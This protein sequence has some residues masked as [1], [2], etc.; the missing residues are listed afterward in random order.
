[1][2]KHFL[3][4]AFVLLLWSGCEEQVATQYLSAGYPYELFDREPG[5]TAQLG[6]I[7]YYR[8]RIETDGGAL[9]FDGY[10]SIAAGQATIPEDGQFAKAKT[11]YVLEA[12]TKMS[13]GDSLVLRLPAEV[14]RQESA[15][16]PP[17]K[18][19]KE[20]IYYLSLEEIYQPA[21]LQALQKAQMD[22][23][24]GL[25]R[26]FL[27]DYQYGKKDDWQTSASGLVYVILEPGDGTSPQ[28]NQPFQ[29]HYAGVRMD[30]SLFDTSITDPFPNILRYQDPRGLK[31]WNE[32]LSYLSKRGRGIFLMPSELAYGSEGNSQLGI[33]PDASVLFYFEMVNF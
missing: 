27:N 24:M 13:V 22:E 16:N 15:N 8:S 21:Q 33:P 30:G 17:P 6:E 1:M 19:A 2:R 23:I 3:P 28:N 18:E 29:L 11:G 7:V 14:L 20:I 12:L 26:N 25:L 9:L 10:H 5:P 31:G 4:M 32:A